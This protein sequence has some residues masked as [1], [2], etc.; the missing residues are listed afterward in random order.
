MIF[1]NY[2]AHTDPITG[3]VHYKHLRRVKE[4]YMP[5]L[6]AEIVHDEKNKRY[7]FRIEPN[8]FFADKKNFA[9]FWRAKQDDEFGIL[10]YRYENDMTDYLFAADVMRF[11]DLDFELTF[12]GISLFNKQRADVFIQTFN[13]YHKVSSV[14]SQLKPL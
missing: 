8:D 13:D 10:A 7:F 5:V 1:D 12:C 2:E 3:R 6:N 11:I 14:T 9:L 4:H